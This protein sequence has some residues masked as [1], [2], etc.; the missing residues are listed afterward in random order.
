M[1]VAMPTA[2]MNGQA[3]SIADLTGGVNG[4]QPY[5]ITMVANVGQTIAGLVEVV[6]NVNRGKWAFEFY[7]TGTG[8]GVWDAGAV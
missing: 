4:F 5:P 8:T 1:N 7:S 6:L 2:P 3:V